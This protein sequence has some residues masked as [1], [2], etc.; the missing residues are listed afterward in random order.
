ML[1]FSL[2]EL[3]KIF[4]EILKDES[5]KIKDDYLHP[6]FYVETEKCPQWSDPH[7]HLTLPILLLSFKSDY[8]TDIV[9]W[10]STS[11]G[12]IDSFTQKTKINL[13]QR[14]RDIKYCLSKHKI[15]DEKLL[16][17]VSNYV[18][19]LVALSEDLTSYSPVPF[20]PKK[21]RHPDV[22]T[23]QKFPAK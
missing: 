2:P 3:S 21:Q 19:F 5:S 14:I 6:F 11:R 22:V 23:L 18:P 13:I 20:V 10:T 9:C 15:I 1:Y 12:I 4:S 16:F 8:C 17:S 7:K